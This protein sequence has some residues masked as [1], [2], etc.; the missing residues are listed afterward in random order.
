VSSLVEALRA[1]DLSVWIDTAEIE[2]HN[3]ITG[4]VR[5]ALACSKTLVPYYSRLYPARRACQWE[6]TNAFIAAQTLGDVRNRIL[7]VNPET[8]SDTG[9]RF[10]HVEPVEL[11]DSLIPPPPDGD[12]SEW[13]L[14]IAAQI[15]THAATVSGVFGDAAPATSRQYGR[16][17]VGASGFMGRHPD[18]WRLHSTLSGS[19]AVLITG[20]TIGDV[21]TATGSG[22]MGKSLL[23]EEYALRFASAYPGGV[24]W[25]Q[26]SMAADAP[27]AGDAQVDAL[28]RELADELGIGSAGRNFAELRGG[29]GAHLAGAGRALWVVDDLPAGLSVEEVRAWL[30][31]HPNARTLITTQSRSYGLGHQLTLDRLPPDDAYRLLTSRREPTARPDDVASAHAIV[32]I[33]GGHP[34]ALAVSAHA[35][36][37]EA[38][39]RSFTEYRAAIETNAINELELATALRPVLPNGHEASIA[40]TLRYGIERLA[41]P[42]RDLL[43]IAGML[44]PR[45]IPSLLVAALLRSAD[46]LPPNRASRAAAT[47]IAEVDALSLL[48]IGTQREGTIVV[49]SL[50]SKTAHFLEADPERLASLLA[51]ATPALV[52]TLQRPDT[53]STTYAS[54]IAHARAVLDNQAAQQFVDPPEGTLVLMSEVARFDDRRGAYEASAILQMTV[55]AAVSGSLDADDPTVVGLKDRLAAT[56]YGAGD[57]TTSRTLREEVLATRE[58][59]LGADHVDTISASANLAGIR[60]KQGELAA[61]HEILTSAVAKLTAQCGADDPMTLSVLSNLAGVQLMLGETQLARDSFEHIWEAR[62]ADT[63]FTDATL[64]D[65]T[66]LATALHDSGELAISLEL[67]QRVVAAREATLDATHPSLISARINLGV[68]MGSLGRHHDAEVLLRNAVRACDTVLPTDHWMTLWGKSAL[69]FELQKLGRAEEARALQEEVL[70]RRIVVLGADHIDTYKA[71]LNLVGTLKESGDL[72]TA[73]EL[74]EGL[75]PKVMATLGRQHPL[76]LDTITVLSD[77]LMAVDPAALRALL[78]RPE[79]QPTPE[80]LA[81]LSTTGRSAR[82]TGRNS[83]CPCGSGKKFKRC[84]GR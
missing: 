74:L 6:L 24:F 36:R 23:A 71:T 73:R 69:G 34:L 46:S 12:V 65:M 66:N 79:Y 14:R 32:E 53:D 60:A 22:G 64:K 16:R 19:D 21:V 55:L 26:A 44:A 77:L 1:A 25:L 39:L 84:C 56:L 68:T 7:V 28:F 67:K 76:T 78:A 72:N 8:A 38:G 43:R 49:H 10:A 57:L 82:R 83:P 48:D 41:P 52:E 18:L 81:N 59:L 31:P 51:A 29:I 15:A 5:D 33:L 50:V 11:R 80:E 30:A 75:F 3:P 62:G 45:E 13:V 2:T 17:L 70:S 54:L 20:A 42:G 47:A 35:L 63:E 61:A 58:R 27:S 40:A 4:S 9:D 37:V